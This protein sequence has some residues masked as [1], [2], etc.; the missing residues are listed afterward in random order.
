MPHLGRLYKITDEY[1]DDLGRANLSADIVSTLQAGCFVGALLA[2]Q[3][4]DRFG[5]RP[6][7]IWGAGGI[8]VIGVILQA[9]ASGHLAAMF[10]GR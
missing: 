7:L 1:T 2:A 3:A 9:A 5:R 10:V 6:V 8:S 4:A